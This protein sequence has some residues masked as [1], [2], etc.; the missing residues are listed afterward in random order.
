R[1][2]QTG[3]S[4]RRPRAW[5][6]VRRLR[7]VSRVRGIL[8]VGSALSVIVGVSSLTGLTPARAAGGPRWVP[9]KNV[10]STSRSSGSS[11]LLPDGR[12]LVAGGFPQ[13]A[14][15]TTELYDPTTRR[16]SLTGTMNEPRVGATA[17]LL[18]DGE[19]LVAGGAGRRVTATAELYD[20]TTGLWSLTD[21]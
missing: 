14:L 8:T 9:V 1:R 16:W 12:V 20:P 21:S 3:S 7:R 11:A 4:R 15:T 5:K 13:K 6:E 2:A 19:V 18:P 10:M 17:T